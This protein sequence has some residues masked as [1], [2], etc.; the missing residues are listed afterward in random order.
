M[1]I[2][3]GASLI[4]YLMLL[5]WLLPAPELK[6]MVS[7]V[8]ISKADCIS[9]LK[10]VCWTLAFISARDRYKNPVYGPSGRL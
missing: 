1:G 7:F 10:S 2:A 8:I 3:K 5:N 9:T 4:N 6:M